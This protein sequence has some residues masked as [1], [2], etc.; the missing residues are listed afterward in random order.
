MQLGIC[1]L[2]SLNIFKKSILY[3]LLW[4]IFVYYFE[5]CSLKKS[6]GTNF[7]GETFKH[8]LGCKSFSEVYD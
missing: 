1:L 3:E 2:Y 6:L 4:Q 8:R 5:Y 7:E